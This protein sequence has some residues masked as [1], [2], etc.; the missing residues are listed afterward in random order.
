MWSASDT[1]TLAWK[2]SPA[3][4]QEPPASACCPHTG[5]GVCPQVV[6]PGDEDEDEDDFVEVPEKEGYEACVPDHL[7]PK[8]GEWWEGHWGEGPLSQG[9]W[10]LTSGVGPIAP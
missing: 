10:A 1:D 2:T 9:P 3:G 6:A 8:D 5:L 4:V 7:W